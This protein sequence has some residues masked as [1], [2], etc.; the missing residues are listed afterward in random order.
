MGAVTGSVP[1]RGP[2][3]KGSGKGSEVGLGW[4]SVRDGPA[5]PAPREQHVVSTTAEPD[6]AARDLEIDWA[7]LASLF[8]FRLATVE[9]LRRLHAPESSAEKMRARLRRLRA[10]GVVDW[11]VPPQSGRAHACFLTEHGA[12]IAGAFPE[13]ADVPVP[14]SPGDATAFRYTMWHQMDVVRTHWPS[15]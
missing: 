2:F 15:S 9:Q 13:M 8:Q 3:I 7:V 12:R 10:E 5:R 6:S 4:A 14:R 1:D 11:L